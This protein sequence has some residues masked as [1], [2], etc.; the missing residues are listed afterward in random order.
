[1]LTG[2]RIIVTDNK[3]NII[4]EKGLPKQLEDLEKSLNKEARKRLAERMKKAYEKAMDGV[5]M[6]GKRS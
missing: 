5:L 3:G 2:K 1:M 6:Y 4:F